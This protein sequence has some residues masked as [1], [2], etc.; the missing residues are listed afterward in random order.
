MGF[1]LFRNE[2]FL[3]PLLEFCSIPD[4]HHLRGVNHCC[5]ISTQRYVK[6]PLGLRQRFWEHLNRSHPSHIVRGLQELEREANVLF[7]GPTILQ[8]FIGRELGA[9]WQPLA[10]HADIDALMVGDISSMN[11]LSR[12]VKQLDSY[13]LYME[14]TNNGHKPV[15]SIPFSSNIRI[16][17]KEPW[18]WSPHSKWACFSLVCVPR[19]TKQKVTLWNGED[20]VSVEP[21]SPPR[22]TIKV[23]I[24]VIPPEEEKE[25]KEEKENN[26][27]VERKYDKQMIKAYRW[28][29]VNE[30]LTFRVCVVG[31]IGVWF[32]ASEDLVSQCAYLQQGTYCSHLHQCRTR[33]QEER[34]QLEESR[35]KIKKEKWGCTSSRFA[36]LIE[37]QSKPLF[38]WLQQKRFCEC[39]AIMANLAL[40]C[41]HRGFQVLAMEKTI[42]RNELLSYWTM[43]GENE[44]HDMETRYRARFYSSSPWFDPGPFVACISNGT[45]G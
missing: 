18:R 5:R 23:R 28:I 27:R 33:S 21:Y 44:R 45:I 42:P 24:F 1:V 4:L 2:T 35:E 8:L 43:V 20:E 40:E 12:L 3:R 38:Q 22:E 15:S 10:G 41:Y 36:P 34:R 25:K 13:I 14:Q 37:R 31:R 19:E 11:A 30:V 26:E 17:N 29:K 7:E 9:E 6:S 39:S 16:F 32:T